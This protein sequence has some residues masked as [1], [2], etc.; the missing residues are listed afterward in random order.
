M[1]RDPTRF[2]LSNTTSLYSFEGVFSK[3]NKD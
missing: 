3:D 1:H 2:E